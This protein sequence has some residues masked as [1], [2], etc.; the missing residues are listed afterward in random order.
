[1]PPPTTTKSRTRDNGPGLDIG[2]LVYPRHTPL[3]L[4]GPWEVLVRLPDTNT[5]LIW[6][7]PGP[8]QAEAGMEITATAAFADAPQLD[9]LVVPGGP[10]QLALMK[11]TLLMDYIRSCANT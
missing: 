1:M 5:H 8:V 7:R 3:D 10:G 4:V 6:T 2:F 11:H 9:L